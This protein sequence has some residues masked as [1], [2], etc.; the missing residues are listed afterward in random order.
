MGPNTVTDFRIPFFAA[1]DVMT[2]SGRSVSL[3]AIM[4]SVTFLSKGPKFSTV[5]S[6]SILQDM[7]SSYLKLFSKLDC[8]KFDFWH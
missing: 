8:I 6:N 4:L 1:S 2:A 7:I 3:E 5:K